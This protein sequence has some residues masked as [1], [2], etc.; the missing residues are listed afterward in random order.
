[1]S[2]THFDSALKIRFASDVSEYGFGAVILHKYKDGNMKALIFTLSSLLQA[3]KI[4][5][6]METDTLA[7]I[8]TVKISH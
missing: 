5:N 8:F 3:E 6:Q 4:Y 2:L 7:I 1:M